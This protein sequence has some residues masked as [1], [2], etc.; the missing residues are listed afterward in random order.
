MVLEMDLRV[1]APFHRSMQAATGGRRVCA[2]T[3]VRE[4]LIAKLGPTDDK[5]PADKGGNDPVD[6]PI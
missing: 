2:A 5:L 3:D 1:C 6:S 4:T